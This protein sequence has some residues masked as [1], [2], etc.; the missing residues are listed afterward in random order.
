MVYPLGIQMCIHVHTKTL[1]NHVFKDIYF[2]EMKIS[3]KEEKKKGNFMKILN[4]QCHRN[5]K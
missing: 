2:S 1:C 5:S 4:S 3:K